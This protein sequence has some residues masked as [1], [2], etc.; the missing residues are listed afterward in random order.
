MLFVKGKSQHIPTAANFVS[1]QQGLHML[2]IPLP[3]ATSFICHLV[4]KLPILL[5]NFLSLLI[6]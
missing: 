1:L 5:A 6:F 3:G 4:L 2:P